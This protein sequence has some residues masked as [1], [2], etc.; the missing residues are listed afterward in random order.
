MQCIEQNEDGDE[1]VDKGKK[2]K[3]GRHDATFVVW[4]KDIIIILSQR[5]FHSLFNLKTGSENES[6]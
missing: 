6:V 1:R 4:K 3:S 5:L 2:R